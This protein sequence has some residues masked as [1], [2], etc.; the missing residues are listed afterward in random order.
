MLKKASVGKGVSIILV[1]SMVGMGAPFIPSAYANGEVNSSVPAIQNEQNNSL[2]VL[3]KLEIE[4]IP[5]D[6]D[7]SPSLYQYTATVESNVQNVTLQVKSDNENAAITINGQTVETGTAEVPLQPGENQIMITVDDRVNTASTYT[8]TVSR[9]KNSNNLLQNLQLSNGELSPKFD[10]AT[11]SYKVQVTNEVENIT[12]TP[13]LAEKTASVMINNTV[14]TDAGT[15]VHLAV[16]KT[17][18]LIVVTAENGEK[19]TYMLEVTRPEKQDE[20]HPAEA[21]SSKTTPISAGLNHSQKSNTATYKGTF[22]GNVA[23]TSQR[24]TVQ[25]SGG[26]IQKPSLA[27]LSALSVT[28]GTWNKTF[29]SN[30]FTY[31]IA[32]ANDIDTVSINV[33][34][35][36]SGASVAIESGT[37]N[38]ISLGS[39]K[40]TIVPIV[41][42]KDDDRKTYILV[43]DKDVPQV[44]A[45]TTA[46]GQTISIE[47]STS[48]SSIKGSTVTT[49]TNNGNGSKNNGSTSFWSRL[50]DSLRSFFSKL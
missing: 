34:P 42:T 47:N 48:D 4:E 46:A 7:F 31:H 50:V 3:S 40:K 41:V 21:S 11:T 20:P 36:N 28:T 27:T 17:E 16:G 13:V 10:P 2:N 15:S 44:T 9:K 23:N 5:F 43:F 29:A 37:N 24:Q 32:V 35:T 39:Q 30:S 19:K 38:T 14:G 49:P 22:N 26:S 8:L 6:Q 25:Q 45:T 1:I 12:I 33:T 18:I